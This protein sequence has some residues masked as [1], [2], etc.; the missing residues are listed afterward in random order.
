MTKMFQQKK[1]KKT[2]SVIEYPQEVDTDVTFH[3]RQ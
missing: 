2:G 3:F 1:K